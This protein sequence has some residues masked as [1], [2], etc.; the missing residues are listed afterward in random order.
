[1][2]NKNPPTPIAAL[3]VLCLTIGGCDNPGDAINTGDAKARW[4][5]QAISLRDGEAVNSWPDGSRNRY[6]ATAIGRSRPTYKIADGLPAV[7]FDGSG[8]YMV[9]G[10][11]ADWSF[12]HDGSEWT[13]FVAFRATAGALAGT[14][15][16][17]DTGATNS[18][19]SGFAISYDDRADISRTEV[20]RDDTDPDGPVRLSL[21]EGTTEQADVTAG[22][23][24]PPLGRWTIVS[25]TFTAAWNGGGNKAALFINGQEGPVSS[26]LALDNSKAALALDNSSAQ[27][28]L[29]IG[30]HGFRNALFANGD[31]N[32]IAIYDRALT[33]AQHYEVIR[34]LAAKLGPAAEVRYP[35]SRKFLEYDQTAY[36]GFGISFRIPSTGKLMVIQR[37]AERHV[38]GPDGELR[39][40]ES[41]D[42]GATWTSRLTYDSE[43]DDRNVSGGLA[44]HTGSILIFFGR[45]DGFKW[46][47]M[48]ALRSTDAGETFSD[49]GAPLPTNGCLGFTPYGPMVE[50]PSGRLL[51]TF[52]GIDLDRETKKVWISESTDDGL[53]WT[54]KADI[55]RGPLWINETSLAWIS[56]SDDATSTLIAVSR[57]DL[58]SGLLQ[59][60]SM[61]GG[62]TWTMQGVIPGGDP[63]DLSPWLY[64]LAG[65]G[66]VAAWHERTNFTFPIRGAVG[67][68]A[69]LSPANWGPKR[70]TY[71]AATR[72]P[73]DSGYP[74]LLSVTG[75]DED[76]VEVLYDRVGRGKANLVMTP[77]SVP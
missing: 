21:A 35:S 14:R 29:N 48:R 20:G 61:D 54:Y 62:G 57:N 49:I 7:H 69:A 52:Y 42:R 39:Q 4:D 6:D 36:Q 45:F 53:T 33:E 2:N 43:Y 72:I 27:T 11:A 26:A 10:N 59:F 66:I 58:G 44:P 1:M 24:R 34:N 46:I 25:A 41:T 22:N 17:L 9:A 28:G 55:Y 56:G 60:V 63:M 65:G 64:R 73:G 74:S 76:L 32:E 19:N 47:D 15:V 77:V 18:A 75:R 67:R 68:D 30:R 50:L 13:V 5:A 12:L 37:K 23:H 31:I 8:N 16:L 70:A 51:Q 38:G 3:V 71:R 40:W